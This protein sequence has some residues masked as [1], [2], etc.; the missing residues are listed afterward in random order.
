MGVC[1]SNYPSFSKLL[2]TFLSVNFI[3]L[4][5]LHII[6]WWKWVD[7]HTL[8]IIK[9]E[10]SDFKI[11]YIYVVTG[12]EMYCLSGCEAQCGSIRSNMVGAWPHKPLLYRRKFSY[13]SCLAW[14]PWVHF[15]V[16]DTTW[17]SSIF[18]VALCNC[19]IL[20]K[21]ATCVLYQRL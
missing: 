18:L 4:S 14:T 8:R 7:K 16:D 3:L 5:F 10:D 21:I 15:S 11:N 20:N 13:W 19:N 9:I 12:K 2:M 1:V 17:H 6:H